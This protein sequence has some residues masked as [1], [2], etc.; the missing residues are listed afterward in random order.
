MR[1][2]VQLIHFVNSKIDKVVNY[3][4]TTYILIMIFLLINKD[5]ICG[6]QL[7]IIQTCEMILDDCAKF[8]HIV[9]H[10]SVCLFIYLLALQHTYNLI[11]IMCYK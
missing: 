8:G 5:G 1:G 9:M 2:V 10:F 11:C 7:P 4:Y 6:L 3:S